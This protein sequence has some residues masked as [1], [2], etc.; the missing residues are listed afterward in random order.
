MSDYNCLTW[1]CWV[2]WLIQPKLA[3]VWSPGNWLLRQA[4]ALIT[5]SVAAQITTLPLSLYVF[6]QFP[7][8]FIPANLVII[9]LTTA[10][11]YIALLVLCFTA[12]PWAAGWLGKLT[13]WL[14][15]IT[16]DT[17]RIIDG[18]PGS[19]IEHIPFKSAAKLCCWLY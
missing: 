15:N 8:Y 13:G 3:W 11:V 10:L 14:I 7:V 16:N 1:Q 19:V 17:V 12:W 2:L 18:W 9:P 5:V 4:W 6:H